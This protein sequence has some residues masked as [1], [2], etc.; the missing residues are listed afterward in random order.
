[1]IDFLKSVFRSPKTKKEPT[2]EQIET[3]KSKI[4]GVLVEVREKYLDEQIFKNEETSLARKKIRK[5]LTEEERQIVE[6]IEIGHRLSNEDLVAK[7]RGESV[8]SY[9]P[10]RHLNKEELQSMIQEEVSRRKRI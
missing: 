4:K 1:M 2:P 9:D 7:F 10:G 5:S 8:T 3:I 6:E